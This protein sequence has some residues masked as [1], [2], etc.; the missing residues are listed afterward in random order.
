MDIYK[1]DILLPEGV[2]LWARRRGFISG[3]SVAYLI[4]PDFVRNLSLNRN[5]KL[6]GLIRNINIQKEVNEPEN[7]T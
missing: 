3:K 2:A 7:I 4:S 6:S 5:A 1:L